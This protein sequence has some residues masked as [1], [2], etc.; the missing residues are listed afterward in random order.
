MG[1][2]GF[3]N[4]MWMYEESLEMPLIVRWPGKVPAGSTNDHMVLNLDFAPT[5][6]DLAGVDIP[7]AM[8]G[9]SFR[10]LLLGQEVQPW[11]DAMYYRFYSIGQEWV[12]VPEHYGIRTGES[13]LMY[14]PEVDEW[15]F[16]NLGN[17][18]GEVVNAYGD[19]GYNKRINELK[20]RLR[21]LKLD[22]ED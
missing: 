16:Y 13:K 5:W 3:Y 8:Q 11:R 6:L 4:K 12:E 19:P 17:D 18:P 21:E 1:D 22:F 2:H 15:E 9:M 7:Q 20:H 10:D 14:F